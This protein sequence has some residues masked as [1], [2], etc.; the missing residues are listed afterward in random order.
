MLQRN[1][2]PGDGVLAIIGS[3]RS[4]WRL[5]IVLRGGAILLAAAFG[6]FLLSAFGLE[7]ARFSAGAVTALR[8]VAWLVVALVAAV[9]L[10]RPLLKRVT[11][12]Q[13]ALYLEEHEPSLE[14]AILGAVEVELSETPARHGASR[15][16]CGQA[17]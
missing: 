13:V 15:D 5:R 2:S 1:T 14:S 8:L 7:A 17:W 4:R 9:F 6:A 11:D 16:D 12:E 3:V 10:V